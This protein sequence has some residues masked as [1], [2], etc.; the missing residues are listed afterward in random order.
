MHRY[1]I[2][3]ICLFSLAAQL[4]GEDWPEFLGPGGTAKSS[5]IVP[6][7][8][9][10]SENLAWKADLPGTGS[11][12]PIIVGDKLVVTCYVAGESHAKRE[13]LCFDKNSG[14]RL[15]SLDFPIDYRE[16]SYQGTSPNTDTPATRL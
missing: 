8:W 11:S 7:T 9:S 3:G 4:S 5:D 13:V 6:T 2:A 10:D 14:K 15:W 16:D 1:L 12:S